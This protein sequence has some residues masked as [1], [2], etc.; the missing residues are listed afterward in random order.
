MTQNQ[1]QEQVQ[2][3][4]QRIRREL[5]GLRTFYNPTAG[6]GLLTREDFRE[7]GVFE[8]A[9]ASLEVRTELL[10]F[11]SAWNNENEKER[12]LWREAIN[13]E[14]NDMQQREVWKVVDEEEVPKNRKPVGCK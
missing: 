10:T 8:S 9:M 6:A 7:V 13:K 1:N 4:E 5:V 12:T 3:T 14:L 11:N 2:P